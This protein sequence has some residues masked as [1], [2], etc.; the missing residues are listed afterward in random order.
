MSEFEDLIVMMNQCQSKLCGFCQIYTYM[1]AVNVLTVAS[2][3]GMVIA[4]VMLMASQAWLQMP[5]LADHGELSRTP[6]M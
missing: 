2:G 5:S 3:D 6:T 4:V 1:Y